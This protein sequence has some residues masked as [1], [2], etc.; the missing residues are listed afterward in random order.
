MTDFPSCFH[1]FQTLRVKEVVFFFIKLCE[2][3]QAEMRFQESCLIFWGNFDAVILRR[4]LF[5]AN[6]YDKRGKVI[7]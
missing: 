4:S 2:A 6:K 1:L 3:T 5:S 7:V